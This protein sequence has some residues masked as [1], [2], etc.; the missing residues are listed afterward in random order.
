MASNLTI[1]RTPYKWVAAPPKRSMRKKTPQSAPRL[2]EWLID[3]SY[4]EPV[5]TIKSSRKGKR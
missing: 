1:G 5:K 3:N 4:V 2:Y